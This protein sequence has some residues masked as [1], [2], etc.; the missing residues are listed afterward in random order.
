MAI[1]YPQNYFNRFKPEDNYKKMV[2]LSGANLQAAEFNE[3]QEAIL[4][5]LQRISNY[6]IKNGTIISG[7]EINNVSQNS[8]TILSGVVYAD[9]STISVSQRNV[10]ITGVG[11]EVLGM[12]VISALVTELENPKL[13]EMDQASP[14]Y[15]QPGAYRVA[16]IGVWKK[17]TEINSDELFFPVFTFN[18]GQMLSSS[19]STDNTE[20]INSLIGKYDYETN[21]NYVLNGLNVQYNTVDPNT[22]EVLLFVSSGKARVSGQ[23]ISTAHQIDVKLEP[24]EDVRLVQGE[25]HVYDGSGVKALRYSPVANIVKVQGQKRITETVTHGTYSGCNDLMSNTPVLNIEAI[26]QGQITYKSG[27]DFISNGDNVDWSPSGAEPAPG[28]TYSVT[29]TYISSFSAAIDAGSTGLVLDSKNILVSGTTYF[30][31]YYFYLRRY[32]RISIDSSGNFI[33]A[34]G[35]PGYSSIYPPQKSANALSLATVY[36]EHGASN[37]PITQDTTFNLTYDQLAV[38]NSKISTLEVNLAQLSLMET[39]RSTDATTNKRNLVVDSLFN[40]NLRDMGTQNNLVIKD[41]ELNIASVFSVGDVTTQTYT[42]PFVEA[43]IQEQTKMTGSKRINPYATSATDVIAEMIVNPATLYDWKYLW[44]WSDADI[45]LSQ[46]RTFTVTLNRFNANE[47]IN[48]NYNNNITQVTA[49]AKGTA[50]ATLTAKAGTRQGSYKIEALGITSGAVASG[51]ISVSVSVQWWWWWWGYDPVAQT[52][53]LNDTHDLTSVAINLTEL[54][55]D[56]IIIRICKVKVGI[57]DTTETI[58]LGR[59][60]YQKCVL[61]WNNVKLDVPVSTNPDNEYAIVVFTS[62]SAGQVAIAKVGQYDSVAKVW[63]SSQAAPGV[64]LTSSNLSTWNAIQDEDLAYK[65]FGAVYQSSITHTI[66]TLNVTGVTD[67]CLK[68]VDY[69][70]D[71][72]SVK[73]Y[74]EDAQGNTYELGIGVPIYTTAL[75]GVVKLKADLHTTDPKKSPIISRSLQ[76]FIGTADKPGVYS[77]NAF[78]I[79][80]GSVTPATVKLIMD[81]YAPAGSSVIPSLLTSSG[82]VQMTYMSATPVGDSWFEST[83]QVTGVNLNSSKLKIVAD[84]TV[85]TSRPKVRKIRVLIS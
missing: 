65:I 73:Y 83:Y 33:I 14:N 59:I 53:Y 37:V 48:V 51:T 61:G 3:L 84:T 15:G 29:Y 60:A 25:P 49:D 7:G 27:I 10:P 78:P 22:K 57:P 66:S 1:Q 76:L 63:V 55:T 41:Q 62:R 67:W 34:K 75:T 2:F 50:T 52:F 26:T 24:V 30:V 4:Y 80:N 77:M 70:P 44:W 16:T 36:L 6:L 43:V 8:V 71:G 21:G 32:D 17:S 23:L 28:S 47:K 72:T 18:D 12:A 39:A 68:G 5:E 69:V 46:D 20:Q 42:L 40:N 45:S 13:K 82:F 35:T 85:P 74:L 38:L 11:I 58:G 19:N 54:P 81:V 9:G 56:D 79:T 64:L 31:D